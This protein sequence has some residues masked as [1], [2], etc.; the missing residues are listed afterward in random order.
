[1][2]W[3]DVLNRNIEPVFKPAINEN[4]TNGVDLDNFDK[5]FTTENLVENET[6]VEDRYNTHYQGFTYVEESVLS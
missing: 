1:V 2:N 5:I 6:K 4:A 3:D